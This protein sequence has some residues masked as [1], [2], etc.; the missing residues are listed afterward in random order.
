[1]NVNKPVL[2]KEVAEV[3][4]RKR[5]ERTDHGMPPWSMKDFAEAYMIGMGETQKT[6]RTVSFETLMAAFVNGYDV[7][8]TPEDKVRDKFNR[9]ERYFNG[10]EQRQ[11]DY[12]NGMHF[13]LE[14]F[15][16]K[17]EGVNA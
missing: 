6:I 1:M 15:N 3:I 9:L 8:K 12:Q 17:I 11:C 2:P 7:E 5:S 10:D 13:I 16:V 14:T 4:E